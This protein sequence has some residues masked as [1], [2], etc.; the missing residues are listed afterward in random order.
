MG[1]MSAVADGNLGKLLRPD[2]APERGALLDLL[3]PRTRSLMR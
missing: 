1:H 2:V 3:P